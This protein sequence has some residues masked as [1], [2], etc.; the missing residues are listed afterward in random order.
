MTSRA[1]LARAVPASRATRAQP[2]VRPRAARAATLQRAAGN[3]ALARFL[4]AETIHNYDAATAAW[5]LAAEHVK[6]FD[7][8]L[9]DYKRSSDWRL[10][11]SMM[12]DLSRN[13]ERKSVRA[14]STL[15]GEA[16]E[17]PHWSVS[18]PRIVGPGAGAGVDL[19]TYQ[20]GVGPRN[21]RAYDE[22][23]TARSSTTLKAGIADACR[24]SPRQIHV[25]YSGH[26]YAR[27]TVFISD[28][29]TFTTGPYDSAPSAAAGP[30]VVVDL[31][32]G[33]SDRFSVTI[34]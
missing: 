15:A 10:I 13:A 1:A 14:V 24:N 20:P 2:N 18:W 8:Q 27:P 9:E 23:K 31:P 4:N 32:D 34:T 3:R 12:E 33:S 21:P 7:R 22:V 30:R 16:A 5:G 29:R 25:R 17:V 6:T 26:D 11:A 19:M 28:G